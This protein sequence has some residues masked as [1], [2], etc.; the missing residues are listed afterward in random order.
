[1]H[2]I[3]PL[4]HQ[5]IVR[6]QGIILRKAITLLQGTP[7]EPT[8]DL[9]VKPTTLRPPT[10]RALVR[11]PIAFL[12]KHTPVKARPRMNG[13]LLRARRNEAACASPTS[14]PGAVTVSK[15]RAHNHRANVRRSIRSRCRLQEEGRQDAQGERSFIPLV[16]LTGHQPQF[17]NK[18]RWRKPIT[19]QM[20]RQTHCPAGASFLA[21]WRTA[22]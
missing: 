9:P 21:F 16:G 15:G 5:P 1:M 6:L 17:R 22:R 4:L 8:G 19:R 12:L 7:A 3:A 10:R 2:N 11:R 14:T 18:P 13:T 20:L